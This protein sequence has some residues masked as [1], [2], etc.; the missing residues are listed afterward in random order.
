L[1]LCA[2]HFMQNDAK[3]AAI[4]IHVGG[5]LSQFSAPQITTGLDTG[6]LTRC[7][8]RYW[9]GLFKS[10]FEPPDHLVTCSEN[11]PCEKRPLA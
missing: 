10:N 2:Q 4:C 6:H 3:G 1:G 8:D 7:R 9:I 11:I 5:P